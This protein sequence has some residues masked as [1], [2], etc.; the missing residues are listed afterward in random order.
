MDFPD[1]T[2]DKNPPANAGD[3]DSIPS[4][5]RFH[6]LQGNWAQYTATA[7]PSGPRARAPQQKKPRQLEVQA[8]LRRIAPT[9]RNEKAHTRQWR[10]SAVKNKEINNF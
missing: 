6:M 9:H 10:S 4:P 2:V 8:P 1:G 3:T 5:G 7:E